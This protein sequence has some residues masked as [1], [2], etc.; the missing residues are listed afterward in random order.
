MRYM[1][2]TGKRLIAGCLVS[3]ITVVMSVIPSYAKTIL[4]GQVIKVIDGD[5]FVLKDKKTSYEIRLWGID[6]PEYRQ[7]FASKARAISRRYLKGKKIEV[8]VKYRDQYDRFVGM[9]TNG[10]VN[11]N[12]ELV[13]DGAA[14]VYKKYCRASICKKWTSLENKARK[15]RKGLWQNKDAVPPWE[16]RTEN[17]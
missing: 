12:Q 16:W 8:Q 5:S 7:P 14:W 1:N 3:I 2:D 10:D 17:R 15:S 6:C 13:A 11:I 9:A 4:S